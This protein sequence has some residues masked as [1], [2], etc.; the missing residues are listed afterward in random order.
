MHSGPYIALHISFVHTQ[1][2]G[3]EA[4]H[5]RLDS[6]RWNDW[7]A[8]TQEDWERMDARAKSQLGTDLQT[9]D[10]GGQPEAL[11]WLYL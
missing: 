6:S 8:P 2:V 3:S 11:R 4:L 9:I 10:G 5:Y 7:I 1:S